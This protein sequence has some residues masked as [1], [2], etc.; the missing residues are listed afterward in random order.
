MDI[1]HLNKQHAEAL[2][3]ML[4]YKAFALKIYSAAFC[5][6]VKACWQSSLAVKIKPCNSSALLSLC[7][8][9]ARMI[10]ACVFRTSSALN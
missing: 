3:K 2:V 1:I 8:Y 4:S 6:C 7:H 10:V 5:F 9:M